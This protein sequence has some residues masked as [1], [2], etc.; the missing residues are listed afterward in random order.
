MTINEFCTATVVTKGELF[1]YCTNHVKFAW[2]NSTSNVVIH[3][4]DK[5][6]L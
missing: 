1:V 2:I 4:Q 5:D 3:E 6:I